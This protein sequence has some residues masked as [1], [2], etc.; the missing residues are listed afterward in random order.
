LSTNNKH[1]ICYLEH[2]LAVLILVISVVNYLNLNIAQVSGRQTEVG[3]RK[4]FGA[5]TGEAVLQYILEFFLIAIFCLIISAVFFILFFSMA[6][7]GPILQISLS[8]SEIVFIAVFLVVLLLALS[9]LAGGYIYL[10]TKNSPIYNLRQRTGFR[11]NHLFRKILLGFQFTTSIALIFMALIIMKQIKLMVENVSKLHVNQVMVV[12]LPNDRDRYTNTEKFYNVLRQTPYIKSFSTVGNN[13]LPTVT[14]DFELFSVRVNGQSKIKTYPYVNVDT[15]YFKL[16]GIPILKGRNFTEADFENRWDNPIVNEAFV[17]SQSWA[18][19]LDRQITYFGSVE[20]GE[21]RIIG[22]VSDFPFRGFQQKNKPMIFYPN[23]G[24][25]EKLL[26]HFSS[27]NTDKIEDIKQKWYSEMKLPLEFRFLDDY[28]LKTV[29]N[30]GNLQWLLFTFSIVCLII[31]GLGLFGIININLIYHQK[32]IA[33]RKVFGA[34]LLGLVVS[35]WK[36]YAFLLLISSILSYPVG[37]ISLNKWLQIFPDKVNVSPLLYIKAIAI[38][39][40]MMILVMIY[41]AIKMHRSKTI[42]WLRNE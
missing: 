37:L 11:G 22:V 17:K 33:I 20:S 5:S 2:S 13:S 10:Q 31:A 6:N 36:E 40:L 9:V 25:S 8:A 41:H 29:E 4:I 30:E 1:L 3:M 14:P 42:K 16:L 39:A 38:V 26:I 19:P 35:T 18:D 32:E 7:E 28:F 27:L 34:R 12:D 24:Q 21:G 23:R 15:S